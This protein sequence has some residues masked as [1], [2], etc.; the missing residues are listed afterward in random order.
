MRPK[1][2]RPTGPAPGRLRSAIAA[3]VLGGALFALGCG[4]PPKAP[5]R[6]IVIL[7][8]ALRADHVGLDGSTLGATPSI[9]RLGPDSIWF[10]RAFAQASWT[11]P[12]VPSLL[13]GLYP[14]EH[15]LVDF[16][17][18][19]REV[20][21]AALA[22]EVTTLAEG[23]HAAGYRTALVGYQSQLSPKFGTAQGFD[24]YNNNTRTPDRIQSRFFEWVDEAPDRPFFAYL[25]YLDIHW[26][27]CPPEETFGRFYSGPSQLDLC[28]DW[29]GL[30]ERLRSGETVLDAEDRKLLAARYT[31]ELA[32]LDQA[33]GLLFD[34]LERRGMMDETLIVLTADHGEE[35]YERG[36]IEHGHTMHEELLRV[37][38]IWKLPRSWSAARGEP[39]DALVEIRSTLPTL[40][41]LAGQPL[42]PEV[43]APSLVPWLA[44]HPPKPSPV[45]AVFAEANGMFSARTDR[46]KLIA[47]PAQD[48]YELYDLGEDPAERHD[49]A[50]ERPE[51]L[52]EMKR[53]LRRWKAGLHPVRSEAA[54]LDQE[55]T[56]DLKALGYIQ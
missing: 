15:G 11:R 35:L 21:G 4:T 37:P 42:P 24:F 54:V 14:S 6:V 8:D 44:G 5:Q 2:R 32:A 16:V 22:E 23:M 43:S 56:E 26:P 28:A 18:S 39:S 36:G 33:L 13:T 25:H 3:A 45:D 12:S 1:T 55:T 38:Y 34:E 53:L 9:D 48:R 41:D 31:E 10:E 20:T 46:W 40:F 29:R 30:R 47:T 19:G 27:Y 51:E 52:A 7:I 49:L 50:A 17:E